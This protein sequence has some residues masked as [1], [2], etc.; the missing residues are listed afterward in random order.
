MVGG[1]L[2]VLAMC[3]CQV[4]QLRSYLNYKRRAQE[5]EGDTT[6]LDVQLGEQSGPPGTVLKV[7]LLKHLI[8]TLE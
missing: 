1:S 3:V 2:C 6:E 8:G 4:C 7:V 5:L